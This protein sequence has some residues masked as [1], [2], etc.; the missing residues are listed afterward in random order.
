MD[1]K[2][3]LTSIVETNDSPESSYML[4]RAETASSQLT[5]QIQK[6]LEAKNISSRYHEQAGI[7]IND[8]TRKLI[9]NFAELPLDQLFRLAKSLNLSSAEYDGG[10]GIGINSSELSMPKGISE[11]KID[12]PDFGTDSQT[13]F[14]RFLSDKDRGIPIQTAAEFLSKDFDIIVVPEPKEELGKDGNLIKKRATLSSLA[15]NAISQMEIMKQFHDHELIPEI[16][17]WSYKGFE[18]FQILTAAYYSIDTSLR[19]AKRLRIFNNNDD[20]EKIGIE[21]ILQA[22]KSATLK[23]LP[24]DKNRGYRYEEDMPI[25]ESGLEA[26]TYLQLHKDVDI[27]IAGSPEG[28]KSLAFGGPL[29]KADINPATRAIKHVAFAGI[30]ELV[31]LLGI[32]DKSDFIDAVLSDKL[33]IP[34]HLQTHFQSISER[35]GIDKNPA[36]A[37][38]FGLLMTGQWLPSNFSLLISR[39][40]AIGKADNLYLE[41]AGE[42][43]P[44]HES[45]VK[46]IGKLRGNGLIAFLIDR[47]VLNVVDST[48]S[49]I[50]KFLNQM[51]PGRI[52]TISTNP[53][54]PYKNL[55]GISE[56]AKTSHAT[57]KE[58][59]SL[60]F[61]RGLIAMGKLDLFPHLR[62]DFNK[63]TPNPYVLHSRFTVVET[64]PNGELDPTGGVMR[65]IVP[66]DLK[67][68]EKLLLSEIEAG[69]DKQGL[70][71][72]ALKPFE[73]RIAA[74]IKQRKL[75]DL[76][77]S[78]IS[79]PKPLLEVLGRIKH[80]R[81]GIIYMVVMVWIIDYIASS[82]ENE[83]ASPPRQYTLEI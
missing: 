69:T 38:V 72:T 73:G 5:Q 29:N 4:Y 80:V 49:Q 77:K 66:I 79:V 81:E 35:F 55:K 75:T 70:I 21:N 83:T 41:A 68:M 46:E 78:L 57:I 74:F 14:Q 9:P 3:E 45:T 65:N 39:L 50:P 54:I 76:E 42:G 34:D 22:V 31:G 48:R 30:N 1:S 71:R 37:K 11:S 40:S 19:L 32:N 58:T 27:I 18:K 8:R 51:Y 61:I 63:D 10:I 7:Y 6:T 53:E 13:I 64:E 67:R 28:R 44:F 16:Y 12:R 47:G 20:I 36:F 33:K 17:N 59:G 82:F 62:P 2:P 23:P 56:R 25:F 43:R 60:D 15:A 52:L 26:F 24:E